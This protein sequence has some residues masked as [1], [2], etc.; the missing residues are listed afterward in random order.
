MDVDLTGAW[1]L[2]AMETRDAAGRVSHPYGERPAG[3]VIY[4]PEGYVCFNIMR[5]E[6]PRGAAD[7]F[8]YCGRYEVRGAT[9]FHHVEVSPF[10]DLIG[11]TV[12]RA[13]ALDG[14]RLILSGRP[15]AGVGG[16]G[17]TRVTWERVRR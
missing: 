16:P 13:V 9:V 7:Y 4:S 11:E 8:A 2:V 12:E 3:Y 10:P 14:D 17:T 6:G 15:A 1:R 5:G